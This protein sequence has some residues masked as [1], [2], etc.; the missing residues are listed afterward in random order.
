[1]IGSPAIAAFVAV[2]AFWVLL[3]GGIVSRA[4]SVRA[5]VVFAL[6]WA[7]GW[8]GLPY[9]FPGLDLFAPWVALLDIG[10]VL[11][12]FKGDVRLT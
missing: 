9:V 7:A 11:A 8:F 4:L 10:L 3:V 1:M 12:I 6:L 5:A 2:A